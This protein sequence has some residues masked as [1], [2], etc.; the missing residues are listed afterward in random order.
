MTLNTVLIIAA[1]LGIIVVAWVMIKVN[2]AIFARVKKKYNGLQFRFLERVN[3][4]MIVILAVILCFSVFGGISRVWS[5]LL[6]GTAIFTA[7]IVYAAQD[8]I[9]D[10]L[11]GLMISIYKPFEIG[12]R[13]ELENGVVGIIKDITMRHVV[14]L[15]IDTQMVVIPNSKLNSM[16]IKNFSYHTSTRSAMFNFNVAYGSDV[17]KAMKVIRNCV[18]ESELSIPNTRPDGTKDYP[19]VYFMS[20]EGSSL[21]LVTTVYYKETTPSERLI[22]DINLRVDK[23]FRENGIEIPFAYLNVLLRDQNKTVTA[24][25]ISKT[26]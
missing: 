16:C 9:K 19:P 3:T 22:S 1:I 15:T 5:T 26:S 17:E 12:N 21:R 8:V 23:A 20:F 4:V 2:H 18:M 14:L 11:S 10:I 13:V 25:K 7:V 24:D 6:G